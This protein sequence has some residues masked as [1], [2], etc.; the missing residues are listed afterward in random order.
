MTESRRRVKRRVVQVSTAVLL[1]LGLPGPVVWAGVGPWHAVQANASESH[2]SPDNHRGNASA[3]ATVE[4]RVA[5]VQ[6]QNIVD[7]EII[8]IDEN[9]DILARG[10]TDAMGKWL[11]SV[12]WKVDPRF[13]DVRPVRTVTA[14]VVATGYNEHVL[15]E[16]PVRPHAVQPVLMTPVGANR[17]NEPTYGLGNL[18]RTEI[19]KMV[20][21]YAKQSGLK[22]Q[23]PVPGEEG[24]APWGPGGVSGSNHSSSNGNHG[25]QAPTPGKDKS[26]GAG[27]R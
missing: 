23:Q 5:S 6:Q 20:D 16:V 14:I 8:V 17:R 10:R 18:H 27:R 25:R 7:A 26:N 15:F 9:G 1:G 12:P 4:F 22:R 19:Q 11:C 3:T 13:D 21:S 2:T 24:Y